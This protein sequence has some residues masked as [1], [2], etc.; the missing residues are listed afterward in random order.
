MPY[1]MDTLHGLVSS[2]VLCRLV[3]DINDPLSG[4]D[5]GKTRVGV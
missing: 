3:K 2:L 5:P 4:A 1:I